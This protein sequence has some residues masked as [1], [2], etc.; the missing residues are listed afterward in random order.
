MPRLLYFTM[1]HRTF[2]SCRPICANKNRQI[3]LRY[4][5]MRIFSIPDVFPEIHN[6]VSRDKCPCASGA[7]MSPENE[8]NLAY[9]K[10]NESR[11]LTI[12]K[13]CGSRYGKA[14]LK[15]VS[16][17]KYFLKF[18]FRM[19]EVIDKCN[20]TVEDKDWIIIN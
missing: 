12:V 4:R 1:D 17:V 10:P 13:S 2:E 8:A 15:D 3:S 18:V 19:K 11:T 14:V 20:K 16:L 6:S 5:I 7:R 9:N